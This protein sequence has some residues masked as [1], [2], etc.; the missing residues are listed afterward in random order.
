MEASNTEDVA[1]TTE[2]P[3]SEAIKDT[4][5]EDDVSQLKHLSGTRVLFSHRMHLTTGRTCQIALTRNL[6]QKLNQ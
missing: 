6:N 2:E 1:T 4:P 5:Q 3:V